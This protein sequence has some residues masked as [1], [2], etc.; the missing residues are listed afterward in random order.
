MDLWSWPSLRGGSV[1]LG[2]WVVVNT[3]YGFSKFARVGLFCFA[4]GFL[5]GVS[6]PS[7]LLSLIMAQ[8]GHWLRKSNFLRVGKSINLKL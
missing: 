6:P 7:T 2:G 5:G 1:V 4:W 3:E 8:I